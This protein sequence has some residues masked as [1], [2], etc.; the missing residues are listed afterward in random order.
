M[1]KFPGNISSNL[2]CEKELC[3]PKATFVICNYDPPIR[4]SCVY[5]PNFFFCCLLRFAETILTAQKTKGHLNLS[6]KTCMQVWMRQTLQHVMSILPIVFDRIQAF[7]KP[8][9]GFQDGSEPSTSVPLPLGATQ[10]LESMVLEFLRR[11][12]KAGG[13]SMAVSVVLDAGRTSNLSIERGCTVFETPALE[14]A[15][16]E[17]SEAARLQ[18]PAVYMRTTAHHGALTAAA[19]PGG[20][21]GGIRRSSSRKDRVGRPGSRSHEDE[22]NNHAQGSHILRS[23]SNDVAPTNTNGGHFENKGLN[24]LE[25]APEVGS[26]ASSWPHSEWSSLV[27][28]LT[29]TGEP[30]VGSANGETSKASIFDRLERTSSRNLAEV[31]LISLPLPK[32]TEVSGSNFSEESLPT[33][34]PTSSRKQLRF[35]AQTS[36]HISSLSDYMWLVVMVKVGEESRW[37][38]RR[39]SKAVEDEVQEF[40]NGLGTLLRVA[41]WFRASHARLLRQKASDSSFVSSSGI[42]DFDL[43]DEVKIERLWDDDDTQDFLLSIK[44][45]FKLRSNHISLAEP[46]KS[47]HKISFRS[48]AT[49]KSPRRI[50]RGTPRALLHRSSLQASAAALFLGKELMH[51]IG[52]D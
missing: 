28:A 35:N 29:G 46:L 36:F 23:W 50:Q 14:I 18:W 24:V 25:Y 44:E 10:D 43:A 51:T 21:L 22:G 5:F 3:T 30:S 27:G 13:P 42:H 20:L 48:I 34:S 15:Q 4:R 37:H 52:V 9:Y 32:W 31:D 39:A 41:D 49:K 7:A 47:S 1:L 16:M 12:E 2:I 6:S 40:V 8:M 17:D 33:A 11:Q 19:V 38:R 26:V 45:A